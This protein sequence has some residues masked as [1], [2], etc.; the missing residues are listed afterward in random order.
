MAERRK[1]PARKKTAATGNAIV[2]DYHIIPNG[3]RRDVE[4]DHSR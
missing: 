2:R 4:R 3:K 1:N